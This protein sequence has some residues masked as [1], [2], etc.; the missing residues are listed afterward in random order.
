MPAVL[1]H[2]VPDTAELW[3]PIRSRLTRPD[4]VCPN[5]P[6]FASPLPDGFAC[7]KEAYLGWLV[8]ELEAIGEPVDLVGHDWGGLLTQRVATTRPEL[9]RTWAIADG[10]MSP[11]FKWHELATQ[12]Q[13]PGVG[14]Q[15][16]ELMTADAT[17]AALRD[18]RH[19]DP[20]GAASRA[21]ETMRR[22]VLDLYRSAVDIAAEWSPR[23]GQPT[24]PACV[25][26]GTHDPYAPPEFGQAAAELAGAPF[27]ELD[28]GHWSIFEHPDESV[29]ALAD[30]WR[31][32]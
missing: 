7:T 15:I 21:D 23:P 28:A 14:E 18:A 26:W 8:G 19:P 12:W 22:A 11:V 2:G 27:L 30:L 10:A 24:P 3:D 6:G 4:V 17:A 32:P 20:E 31:A 13:T 9:L 29:A 25:F 1:V 16:V 5:L